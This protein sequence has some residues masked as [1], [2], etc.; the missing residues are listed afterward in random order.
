[1]SAAAK[2]N[3]PKSSK[4]SSHS[5]SKSSR[6]STSAKSFDST[7]VNASANGA[8]AVLVNQAPNTP[9]SPKKEVIPSQPQSARPRLRLKRL[10]EHTSAPP[11][12]A[13][14][15]TPLIMPPSSPPPA[16]LDPVG[17]TIPNLYYAEP[18]FTRRPN[19][20]S[21]DTILP[22][23]EDDADNEYL[24][25]PVHGSIGRLLSS[26][27]LLPDPSDPTGKRKLAEPDEQRQINHYLRIVELSTPHEI[28]SPLNVKSL[29]T[30]IHDE[31]TSSNKKKLFS[32][33][34]TGKQER[35]RFFKK[36]KP[37]LNT[38]NPTADTVHL[39]DLTHDREFCGHLDI[40][41]LPQSLQLK[42]DLLSE[43]NYMGLLKPIR[44]VEFDQNP[45]ITDLEKDA[46]ETF[47]LYGDSRWL[48]DPDWVNF[49]KI[50]LFETIFSLAQHM[51]KRLNII[52]FSCSGP[53]EPFNDIRPESQPY[54]FNM[55]M[56]LTYPNS[57]MYAEPLKIL[58][59]G[60]DYINRLAFIL[61]KLLNLELPY[62]SLVSDPAYLDDDRHIRNVYNGV[63]NFID[64]LFSKS[65]YQSIT[66][67]FS[68]YYISS[69]L[70]S[71]QYNNSSIFTSNDIVSDFELLLFA[72]QIYLSGEISKQ[73]VGLIE[74][75][76]R[77]IDTTIREK[78]EYIF[79][80]RTT[81]M[82]TK[83]LQSLGLKNQVF[84]GQEHVNYFTSVG[85]SVEFLFT[86]LTT[87]KTNYLERMLLIFKTKIERIEAIQNSLKVSKSASSN[88]D[89]IG[90]K[91]VK[92]ANQRKVVFE[93]L[94]KKHC[95]HHYK[96]KSRTPTDDD[97]KSRSTRSYRTASMRRK[98]IVSLQKVSDPLYK[99]RDTAT[100]NR[101][102]KEAL[103]LLDVPLDDKVIRVLGK[104]KKQRTMSQSR[105]ERNKP[106]GV[107]M[108]NRIQAFGNMLSKETR[109]KSSSRK[110]KSSKSST[111]KKSNKHSV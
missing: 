96:Y 14:P 90:Y 18:F 58:K 109:K 86:H 82:W 110:G 33:T 81:G 88:G 29:V 32:S 5:S 84:N 87:L 60:C 23:L 95:T 108:R 6:T 98:K 52:I 4:S 62:T 85:D 2:S 35:L 72:T 67:P 56:A 71:L 21:R 66:V 31:L 3:S 65:L 93:N 49:S 80:Y 10:I 69:D 40:S 83:S 19:L 42:F 106:G 75:A 1:M 68:V 89:T 104:D 94:V 27:N 26:G 11:L 61:N 38:P 36:I 97:V 46:L 101:K 30:N 34:S 44:P 45:N 7:K 9:V 37:F 76:I 8:D 63:T 92:L 78:S 73:L 111:S 24:Y 70:L 43:Q 25:F 39:V 41:K 48:G 22:N 100:R 13:G 51:N 64:Q 102:V 28:F 55:N 17:I 47:K 50:T 74:R 77:L 99:K 91:A 54:Y 15:Q 20:V 79:N 103:N 107:F 57:R 53:L 12:S 59:T 105:I 16:Y